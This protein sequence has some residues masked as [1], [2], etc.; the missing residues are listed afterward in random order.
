MSVT[1]PQEKLE[2][3]LTLMHKWADKEVTNTHDLRT[4]LSKLFYVA[5]LTPCSIIQQRDA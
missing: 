5:M 4:L 2:E 3:V 1:L